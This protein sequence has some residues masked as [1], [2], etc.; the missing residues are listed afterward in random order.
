MALEVVS[1]CVLGPDHGRYRSLWSHETRKSRAGPFVIGQMLFGF[2][3]LAMGAVQA[4]ADRRTG[5]TNTD[6]GTAP[7]VPES[8]AGSGL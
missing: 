4:I 2:A 8:R 5:R 3:I 1:D 6:I 7:Y